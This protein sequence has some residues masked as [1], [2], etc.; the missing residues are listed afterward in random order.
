MPYKLANPIV[1]LD[2][3]QSTLEPG[4]YRQWAATAAWPTRRGAAKV[5]GACR[6]RAASCGGTV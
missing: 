5:R 4:L 2:H 6:V 3:E 1:T